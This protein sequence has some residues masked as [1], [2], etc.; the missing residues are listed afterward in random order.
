MLDKQ[1]KTK[2]QPHFKLA[3]DVLDLQTLKT[4]VI[5]EHLEES[6]RLREMPIEQHLRKKLL[7]I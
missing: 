6:I 7:K 2:I 5:I 4:N 3:E 1:Q